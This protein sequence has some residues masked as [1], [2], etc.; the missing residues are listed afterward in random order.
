MNTSHYNIIL[1]SNN[2]NSTKTI[3]VHNKFISKKKTPLMKKYSKKNTLQSYFIQSKKH[4]YHTYSSNPVVLKDIHIY[5]YLFCGR[6]R[7]RPVDGAD[8][9]FF[10]SES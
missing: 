7:R 9:N 6:P 10:S 3:A 1:L 8:V 4:V 2:L 5:M